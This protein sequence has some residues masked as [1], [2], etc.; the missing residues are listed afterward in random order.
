MDKIYKQ[1]AWI[2]K[3]EKTIVTQCGNYFM[4]SDEQKIKLTKYQVLTIET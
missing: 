2:V 4:L 1:N 3:F